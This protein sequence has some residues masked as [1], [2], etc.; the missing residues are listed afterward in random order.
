MKKDIIDDD[1][2]NVLVYGVDF[3]NTWK[4]RAEIKKRLDAEEPDP[5]PLEGVG[6]RK[7]QELKTKKLDI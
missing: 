1:Y 2:N 4:I 5:N 6:I 3:S 7:L